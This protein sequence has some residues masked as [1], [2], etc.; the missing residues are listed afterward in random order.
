MKPANCILRY[1]SPFL[2]LKL[3]D[4]GA[5]AVL[6]SP[7]TEHAIP[8]SPHRT[9]FR[10][11]APEILRKEPY[12]YP[13]DIW[14][15]GVLMFEIMQSDPRAPAVDCQTQEPADYI[16]PQQALI[17]RVAEFRATRKPNEAIHLACRLLQQ[18]QDLRPFAESFRLDKWL[19]SRHPSVSGLAAI[20]GSPAKSKARLPEDAPEIWKRLAEF[21]NVL[22]LFA[23]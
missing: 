4:F 21:A 2:T 10:Y 12:G 23:P 5:S 13:A 8:L 3:A 1:S 11:A 6:R 19:A 17:S 20:A 15:A 7:G 16:T 18:E 14:S 22:G 9:T